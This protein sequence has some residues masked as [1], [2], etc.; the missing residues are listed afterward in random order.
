[1]YGCSGSRNSVA[2]GRPPP[3]S[4]P[5]YITATRSA[6]SATIP[7]S[8]V[9]ST[10]AMPRSAWRSRI[11]SRICAWMVTSR[12]VVGSSAISSS[13]PAASAMAIITR[14]ACRP[15]AG[16]GTSGPAAWRRGCRPW[17]ASR[18]P[19][20]RRPTACASLVDLVDL[21]DLEA[22]SVAG[23]QRRVGL[24]EDHGDRGRRGCRASR[25]VDFASSVLAVEADRAADDAARRRP[26]SRSTEND[27]DALAR[28]RLADQAERPRPGRRRGR[29][30]RPPSRPRRR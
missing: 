29:R 11:R 26:T 30:R 12:A 28:A 15:R 13:G 10:I 1:M 3:R 21:G 5:A 25:C 20:P 24:L 19:A 2:G 4:A 22:G 27:G 7:R 17:R 18:R 6:I 8:W 9:M 16:A 14:W 23:V